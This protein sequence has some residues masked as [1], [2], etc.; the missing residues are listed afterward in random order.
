[1]KNTAAINSPAENCNGAYT[2]LGMRLFNDGAPFDAQRCAAVCSDTSSYNINHNPDPTKPP[3][4]CK[5]F[6]TYILSRNYVSQGQ[7]C[8]LYSQY[9]DPAVYAV[10]D[11]QYDAKG[12]HFTISS[13]VFVKNAT[14]VV[15]P[16]CPSN[17][18]E[19]QQD[20]AAGAF[21]T[22]YNSYVAPVTTATAIG[23]TT[24]VERCA[25][26]TPRAQ[27]RDDGP[28]GLVEAVLA[29]YPEKI[30]SHSTG[31]A[32]S[33][34]IAAE[35]ITAAAALASATAEAVSSLGMT[36]SGNSGVTTTAPVVRRRQ[37]SVTPSILQGR[38]P[39]EIASVCSRVATGTSTTTRNAQ[40]TETSDANC[41]QYPSTCSDG[42]PPTLIVGDFNRAPSNYDDYS[43]K[44]EL[45]FPV[46]IY[47]NCSTTVH[48]TTNGLITLGDF[49]TAEYENYLIPTNETYT[50][51]GR[52]P[53]LFVLWDDLYIYSGQRHYMDYSICGT[54]G[55]RSVTFDWRMGRY[56][57]PSDGPLYSFSATLYEAQPSRA[58]I[59]YFGTTDQGNSSSVG[60]QGYRAGQGKSII[61]PS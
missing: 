49:E 19:L 44:V 20:S 36:I 58:F 2:Y 24:T 27:K 47:D 6:N 50:Y 43:F 32:A 59:Q 12:N 38:D 17:V 57:A 4:L 1:L 11:G 35:S 45:P 52:R 29:V 14:D 40:A 8:A 15:T 18:V 54:P 16:V 9:W 5:Y 23:G 42:S 41:A 30:N 39:R 34:T 31:A 25:A 53:A 48:P 55:S 46:C 28:G 22:S 33:V 13:S 60:M 3:T 51:L 56:R 37:A 10:N 61:F 21:C 7:V 26:L